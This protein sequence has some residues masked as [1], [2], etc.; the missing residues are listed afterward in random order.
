MHSGS[1]HLFDIIILLSAAVF[2]VIAFWKMNIS[3]V[4]G[5][6]VAGA[7]IGS[8]GFNLINS[9]EVMD[10]F[11]EFGV[12]FLL[13][14]IGLELTFE[15]LIAMRRHVFG[16]GSLQVI[17]TMIAIWC[18]ALAFGVSINMAAVIGGGLALSSTAIVLQVLQE[19][20]SQASQVGR[21][22]I[23]VLLMQDFAVVP[24]I[25][26]VPL[27]TGNSEHSLIS[28]LAGSLVQ[29]AIAL[30]LIFVTGR[31]LLRPLFSVIAK[32]ESNEIF[33]STTL[34][35]ILGSAFITEQ[36]H[37][38]M[39]LGA[40]VAGLLVAETEHRNSVEH[41]V[42][43][44]KDL[45]LGLFFMTV[46][47]SIDIDLLLNKLPLVTLLSIILIVLKTSIIYTLCRFFGFRSA[48]AIQAGLL[49]AQG[50]EF[51]FILFRLADELDVL[52]S[53]IAQV[54]MMVTTVTMAFTPLLSGI[55]DWI[56][57]SFSTEKIILD[58]EAIETDTQDLY[59]HVIVA[60]FGRVGY[61][62]TK[63]LTAEHLSYVIVDIQSKIVKEG[64]ND[65]F[66]IYLGDATRYEILKSVGIE[67]AQALVVSIKN[68]VTIKKIVSLVAANFPHVNIIIRLPDLN[69]VEVYKDLG[70][71]K[72]IPET[73][74]IGLQ[75][76]GA[77]LSL[78]G[79]SESG[80]TSLKGKFRKGNYSMLKE[81]GNDKDE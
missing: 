11:A 39:A 75:L 55:G 9:A 20:G 16:F 6:F 43:P 54:L 59:N 61:M 12:V 17:V 50:G 70:A 52:S 24:L 53:E 35:I 63:M 36:F 46:G 78:S 58:D 41:A 7:L 77:A 42:L 34:L 66:P 14:I 23:A 56:A 48:P 38:S 22:S 19:K 51:A 8:H 33:I 25:V 5:Y 64:K 31:L 60:G 71:S 67:R 74:E 4:L 21:L 79:I 10:N 69:N 2:I 65:S 27:L 49:L 32:M 57:N 62:V 18:I 13:F 73:S 68:E 45:F 15:R 26:L 28:S 81:L 37:L 40:F 30:V 80:V 76:G 44:F 47:M 72:I 29:A 3:P 1:Q